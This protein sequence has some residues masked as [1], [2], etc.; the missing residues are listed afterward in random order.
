MR[1]IIFS[2]AFMVCYHVKSLYLLPW[3]NAIHTYY[4][5]FCLHIAWENTNACNYCQAY[6]HVLEFVYSFYL[7]KL[8]KHVHANLKYKDREEGS[9]QTEF[10]HGLNSNPQ[11]F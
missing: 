7:K 1:K 4:R 9:Y 11:K 6:S 5:N 2:F 10:S 8:D 3:S